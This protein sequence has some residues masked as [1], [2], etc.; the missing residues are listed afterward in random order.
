MFRNKRQSYCTLPSVMRHI[1][2]QSDIHLLCYLWHKSQSYQPRRSYEKY[3]SLPITWNLIFSKL[4]FWQVWN[5]C[6][7]FTWFFALEYSTYFHFHIPRYVPLVK[8]TP[9]RPRAIVP[10]ASS[11]TNINA[12]SYTG[13]LFGVS[14]LSIRKVQQTSYFVPFLTYELIYIMEY[15][16]KN[17]AR[18]DSSDCVENHPI[19][20][21][22][23]ST[24]SSWIS[25]SHCTTWMLNLAPITSLLQSIF[26]FCHK[27]SL[28][29]RILMC[30]LLSNEVTNILLV[31]LLRLDEW[32]VSIPI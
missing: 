1:M 31:F 23:L 25:A 20:S 16:A 10:H 13:F 14:P 6:V 26:S 11:S 18:Q 22:F 32:Y 28:T 4:S 5:N 7:Y 9:H 15:W 2:H 19:S 12:V 27:T 30:Q 29:I 3:R 21:R 24:V 8:N 17:S